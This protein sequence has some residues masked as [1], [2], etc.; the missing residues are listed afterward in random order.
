MLFLSALT[1]VSHGC[2]ISWM[3][4]HVFHTS[5]PVRSLSAFSNHASRGPFHSLQSKCW[6]SSFVYVQEKACVKSI[7][8]ALSSSLPFFLP[9]LEH[10]LFVLQ[11]IMNP[12]LKVCHIII[13]FLKKHWIIGLLENLWRCYLPHQTLRF[14]CW[15]FSLYFAVTYTCCCRKKL[16]LFMTLWALIMNKREGGTFLELVMVVRDISEQFLI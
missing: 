6:D 9:C 7:L 14:L 15:K 1:N 8:P 2:L 12:V 13:T 11:F 5:R 16:N 10:P 3:F 4:L